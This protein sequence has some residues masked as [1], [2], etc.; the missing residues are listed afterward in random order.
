M[1]V[2]PAYVKSAIFGSQVEAV[3]ALGDVDQ[4]AQR[5]YPQ[6]YT[7]AKA[8]KRKREIETAAEP[9]VTSDAIDAALTGACGSKP[10]YGGVLDRR[11]L[12]GWS[13]YARIVMR[14]GAWSRLGSDPP[15]RWSG[16]VFVNCG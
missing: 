5:V 11:W 7:D 14:V 1:Q 12:V 6:L 8:D 2:Q 13:G 15:P 4:D 9:T 10:E 3:A 16:C